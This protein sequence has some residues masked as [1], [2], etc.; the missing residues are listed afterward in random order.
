MNRRKFLRVF[1]VGLVVGIAGWLRVRWFRQHPPSNRK[2]P[3]GFQD[4]AFDLHYR[5]SFDRVLFVCKDREGRYSP[6]IYLHGPAG[7][8]PACLEVARTAA[9]WMRANEAPDSAA[10]LCGALF[11][12]L[13]FDV[14][15]GGGVSLYNSPKPRSDGSVDW[16][17]YCDWS[18]DLI[19][20]D[21]S[22]MTAECYVSDDANPS[23]DAPKKLVA[24]LTR[25][26]I[27]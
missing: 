4:D 21:V 9:P 25:L 16:Q 20:I 6:G 11:K 8:G 15:G 1:L 10:A 18:V 14:N 3:L 27:P 13:G 19:L 26:Q 2:Q 22:R 17:E 5:S 12:E 24:R 7:G 23:Y